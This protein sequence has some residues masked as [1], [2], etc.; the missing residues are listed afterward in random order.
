MEKDMDTLITKIDNAYNKL[1]WH[2]KLCTWDMGKKRFWKIK[3]SFLENLESEGVN[4]DD[5]KDDLNLLEEYFNLKKSFYDVFSR[6]QFGLFLFLIFCL[7][8]LN[9]SFILSMKK[10]MKGSFV[11]I[12]NIILIAMTTLIYMILNIIRDTKDNTKIRNIYHFLLC[13]NLN[14]KLKDIEDSKEKTLNHCK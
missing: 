10:L 14:N 4:K 9:S 7:S 6:N 2:E 5:L 8:F 1:K 11:L 12:A 3:N 13:E